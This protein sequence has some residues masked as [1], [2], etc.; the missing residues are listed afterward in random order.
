[1]LSYNKNRD[2][3]G[4]MKFNATLLISLLSASFLHVQSQQTTYLSADSIPSVM[5]VDDSVQIRMAEQKMQLASQMA[6]AMVSYFIIRV[7][8]EKFG[9]AIFI[10]G[11]M[12]IEQKSIPAISGNAGFASKEDAEK[13][14]QLVVRKIK[15]GEMPPKVSVQELEQLQIVH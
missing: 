2:I 12:Y 14:V 6:V 11:Q 15:M 8:N 13:V 9:Y 5:M 10:D 1:M 7:P 3:F 4:C